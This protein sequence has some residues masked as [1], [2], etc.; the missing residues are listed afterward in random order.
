M[1]RLLFTIFWVSLFVVGISFLYAE[2]PEKNQD[3]DVDATEDQLEAD[4]PEVIRAK[5]IDT[6]RILLE[7]RSRFSDPLKPIQA[8]E[9]ETNIKRNFAPILM[10]ITQL[11]SNTIEVIVPLLLRTLVTKL[12]TI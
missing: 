9:V 11:A 12:F 1:P 8:F 4:L 2:E 3:V 6:T 5:M 10:L 7:P